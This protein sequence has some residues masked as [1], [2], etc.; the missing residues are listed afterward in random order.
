MPTGIMLTAPGGSKFW[1]PCRDAQTGLREMESIKFTYGLAWGH[2]ATTV[3]FGSVSGDEF[4]PS[5]TL[6]AKSDVV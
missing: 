2:P 6:K 1:H 3:E 5:Q 4:T